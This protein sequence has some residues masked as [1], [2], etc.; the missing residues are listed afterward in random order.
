[1]KKK[2]MYEGVPKSNRN[3]NIARA[4]FVVMDCVTRRC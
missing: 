1:M 2:L 4:R 3:C